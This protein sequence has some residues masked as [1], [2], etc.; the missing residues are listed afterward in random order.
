MRISFY[1]VLS[2]KLQEILTALF[3]TRTEAI[4]EISHRSLELNNLI[5]MMN[6]IITLNSNVAPHRRNSNVIIDC[7]K[8]NM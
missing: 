4:S 5:C 1:S 8:R 2:L 7:L 6:E 3:V